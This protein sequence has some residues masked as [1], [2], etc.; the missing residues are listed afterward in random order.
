MNTRSSKY[1][2]LEQKL[3][4]A[5]G[6]AEETAN[7]ADVLVAVVH[8][9][10]DNFMRECADID[11]KAELGGIGPVR[12]VVINDNVPGFRVVICNSNL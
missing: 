12:R 7:P 2:E 9:K 8:P 4:V 10:V 5:V 3:I 1:A 11:E 6:I